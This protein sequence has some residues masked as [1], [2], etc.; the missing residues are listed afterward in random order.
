MDVNKLAEKERKNSEEGW[1]KAINLLTMCLTMCGTEKVLF[2][3]VT[4]WNK[5]SAL[6]TTGMKYY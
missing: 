3:H 6:E 2:N 5:L 4:K 1:G